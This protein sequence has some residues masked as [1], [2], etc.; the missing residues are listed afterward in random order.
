MI[1][2]LIQKRIIIFGETDANKKHIA[3][4]EAIIANQ[5]VV[6]DDIGVLHIV[7]HQFNFEMQ[8]LLDDF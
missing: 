4:L 3:Q 8:Y 2:E 7:M 1:S 6:N 5:L